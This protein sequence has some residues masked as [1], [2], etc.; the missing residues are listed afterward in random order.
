MP[1]QTKVVTY[2]DPGL[3]LS[4][5]YEFLGEEKIGERPLRFWLRVAD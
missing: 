2:G 3:K 1:L 5:G 4:D